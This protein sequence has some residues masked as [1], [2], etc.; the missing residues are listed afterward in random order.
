MRF[1]TAS[2]GFWVVEVEPQVRKYFRTTGAPVEHPEGSP[3]TEGLHL[4]A[5]G[6]TSAQTALWYCTLGGVTRT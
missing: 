5:S 4:T 1:A 3:G 6:P 2:G